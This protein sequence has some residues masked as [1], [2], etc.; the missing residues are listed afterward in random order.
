MILIVYC[1]RC[2]WWHNS[3]KWLILSKIVQLPSGFV[4]YGFIETKSELVLFI[5]Q[6]AVIAQ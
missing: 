5:V 3:D 2:M 6:M 4:T 1:G